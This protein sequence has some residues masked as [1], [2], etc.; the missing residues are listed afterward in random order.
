MAQ[1][2]LA[3]SNVRN[4]AKNTSSRMLTSIKRELEIVIIVRMIQKQREPLNA[5]ATYSRL[6]NARCDDAIH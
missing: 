2:I 6:P 5:S 1:Q 4:F 3:G